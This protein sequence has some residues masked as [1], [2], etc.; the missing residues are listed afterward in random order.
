MKNYSIL[1]CVALPSLAVIVGLYLLF[2]V[3]FEVMDCFVAR[4]YIFAFRIIYGLY[5]NY[6]AFNSLIIAILRYVLLVFERQAESFG[7]RRLKI[8]SISSSVGVPIFLTILHELT[9]PIE[10]VYISVLV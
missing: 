10:Q 6:L 2:G 5:R 4:Y 3:V 8:L 9:Q 1:Q 7:V